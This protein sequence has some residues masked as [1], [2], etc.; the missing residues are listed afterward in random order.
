MCC[1][2]LSRADLTDHQQRL[3]NATHE[4]DSALQQAQDMADKLDV[5]QIERDQLQQELES[6][7]NQADELQFQFEELNSRSVCFILRMSLQL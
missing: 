1:S 3:D 5:V 6:A 7:Q 2:E 4:R